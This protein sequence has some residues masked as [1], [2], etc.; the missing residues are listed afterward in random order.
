MT[1]LLVEDD[2][3]KR[4]QIESYLREQKPTDRLR[5]ARSL[6][7]GLDALLDERYDLVLL[8]MSMPTFDVG[9]DEETGEHESGGT[10]QS[11]AGWDLLRQMDR[12]EIDAPVIVISGYEAFPDGLTLTE[13]DEALRDE[14]PSTYYGYVFYSTGVAGWREQLTR[15]LQRLPTA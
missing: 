15:A 1:I 13:L 10:P 8:D 12:Y 7:S 4:S 5:C 6:Q 14:F 2:D 11:F 3:R 9:Y